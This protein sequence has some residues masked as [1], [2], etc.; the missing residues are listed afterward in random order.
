MI[1]PPV[2]RP[3]YPVTSVMAVL[4]IVLVVVFHWMLHTPA[5]TGAIV[6]VMG[7][8]VATLYLV[9]WYHNEANKRFGDKR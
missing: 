4:S 1:E 6:F 8:A 2:R 3:D 9:E 5:A 7:L